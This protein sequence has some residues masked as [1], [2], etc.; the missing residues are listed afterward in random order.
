MIDSPTLA[1]A[2]QR[3]RYPFKGTYQFSLFRRGQEVLYYSS[4]LHDGAQV[5]CEGTRV[6]LTAIRLM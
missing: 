1:R 5:L 6:P 4:V 3:R 2:C